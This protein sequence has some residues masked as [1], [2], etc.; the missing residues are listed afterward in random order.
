MKHDPTYPI[1]IEANA[2]GCDVFYGPKFYENKF[3]VTRWGARRFARMLSRRRA[4]AA[5]WNAANS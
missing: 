5:K 4:N 2:Y 1:R 3:F